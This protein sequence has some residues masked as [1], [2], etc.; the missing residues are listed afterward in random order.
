M[1]VTFLDTSSPVWLAVALMGVGGASLYILGLERTTQPSSKRMQL[2]GWSMMAAFSLL[3]TSLLFI[4]LVLV[5]L[6]LP[7]L[8]RRFQDS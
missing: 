1:F 7:A 5:L 4:P 3:P 8:L 6:A 2:V